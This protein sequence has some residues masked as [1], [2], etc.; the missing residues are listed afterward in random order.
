V[1]ENQNK[2]LPFSI[3]PSEGRIVVRRIKNVQTAGIYQPDGAQ[4]AGTEA[5]VIST[6][7]VAAGSAYAPNDHIFI[8]RYTGVPIDVDGNDDNAL[9]VVKIEDVLGRKVEAM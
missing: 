2:P 5:I 6:P 7:S 4:D 9:W 3:D 1:S 8:G